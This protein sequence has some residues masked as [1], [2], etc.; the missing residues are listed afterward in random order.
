ML[1]KICFQGP[2]ML[3]VDEILNVFEI[4]AF[5]IGNFLE[6]MGRLAPSEDFSFPFFRGLLCPRLSKFVKFKKRSFF[7]SSSKSTHQHMTHI[8]MSLVALIHP[9]G[10]ILQD[11]KGYFY[12]HSINIPRDSR[13]LRN[14]SVE[15]WWF[16]VTPREGSYRREKENS[17]VWFVNQLDFTTLHPSPDFT[18]R[19]S[20]WEKDK[21]RQR[22]DRGKNRKKMKER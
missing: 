1:T 21:K 22:K 3:R 19:K 11:I 2:C 6:V 10:Q 5:K 18:R 13:R 17:T 7:F 8:H 9:R 12:V 16:L 4:Y 15:S 14:S 20:E